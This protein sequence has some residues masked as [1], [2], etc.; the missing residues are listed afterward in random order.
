MPE[1][2][3]G[4]KELWREASVF[5]WFSLESKNTNLKETG[6]RF[7]LMKSRQEERKREKGT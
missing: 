7:P 6:V 3:S 5:F 4:A 1:I 2:S